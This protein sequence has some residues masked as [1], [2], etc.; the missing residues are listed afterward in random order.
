MDRA[1]NSLLGRSLELPGLAF[2]L[3]NENLDDTEC[4]SLGDFSLSGDCP[5]QICLDPGDIPSS[6]RPA[7][8]RGGTEL[9]EKY[10]EPAGG[11]GYSRNQRP[12]AL[13]F[14]AEGA[15]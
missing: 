11:S 5:W 9:G 12:W 2:Y 1:L 6:R 10:N 4:G 15:S 7:P 13:S 14:A 8:I 3:L